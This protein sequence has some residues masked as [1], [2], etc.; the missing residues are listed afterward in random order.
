MLV[1][2]S[3]PAP[4]SPL[5]TGAGPPSS[6]CQ[7][8][9]APSRGSSRAERPGELELLRPCLLNSGLGI[10][11]FPEFSS[12]NFEGDNPVLRDFPVRVLRTSLVLHSLP[13]VP[14]A[15]SITMEACFPSWVQRIQNC[16]HFSFFPPPPS[17]YSHMHS[18][19]HEC[20]HPHLIFPS[21][22]KM[23]W[24]L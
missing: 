11:R 6:P 24:D 7:K 22:D 9:P 23:T 14:T 20:C 18:M 8:P 3:I 5:R 19:S 13:T 15:L 10:K 17:W 21:R 4:R 12:S 16:L 2:C 1:K